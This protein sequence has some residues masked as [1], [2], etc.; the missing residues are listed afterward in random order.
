M[1]S[2]VACVCAAATDV[3]YVWSGLGTTNQFYENGKVQPISN[4][5]GKFSNALFAPDN[6]GA[7]TVYPNWFQTNAPSGSDVG[8]ISVRARKLT[9]APR[10]RKSLRQIAVRVDAAVAQEWPV[11]ARLFNLRDITFH[12]DN[13]FV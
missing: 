5:P 4:E 3:G 10:S 8:L 9:A 12:N 2:S 6:D 1:A 13:L 7:L 11:A